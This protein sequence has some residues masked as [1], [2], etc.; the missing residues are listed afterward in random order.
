M[1]NE[2]RYIIHCLESLLNQ[3]IPKTAYEIIVIDDGSTDDS[4]SVVEN[5]SKNL[6]IS[7]ISVYSKVN[8]GLSDARNFG[9]PLTKGKY[10][11]FVDSDDYIASNVLKQLINYMDANQLNI[12]TF[13]YINTVNLS[14]KISK[15]KNDILP[16][17][18]I[19]DGVTHIANNHFHHAVW[20][21]IIE[22][23]FLINNAILFVKNLLL[24]DCVFTPQLFLKATKI[25]HLPL[26]VYRYSQVNPDSI[27][28]KID[29]KHIDKMIESH[30]Y[31]MAEINKLIETLDKNNVIQK[32]CINRLENRKQTLIFFLISKLIKSDLAINKL[33]STTLN[34]K[35]LNAYP[36]DNFISKKYNGIKYEILSKL[37]GNP[38]LL[39]LFTKTYRF[40]R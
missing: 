24:E 22:R 10:I 39:I 7:N 35:K 38:K 23:E 8:G 25:A 37:F 11:Y 28:R 20:T 34:F 14:L 3:N 2:D 33:T 4:F 16:E 5:F 6:K 12:V 27:M 18:I 13:D 40:L 19:S 1:Y 29:L 15:N 26:D 30:I 21:Y 31:I 36:F 17:I 9:I 32:K